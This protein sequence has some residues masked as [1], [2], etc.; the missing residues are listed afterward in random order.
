MNVVK[1]FCT[2]I[3]SVLEIT[4]RPMLYR[5]PYRTTAEAFKSDWQKIAGD[6]DSVMGKIKSE[7]DYGRD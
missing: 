5:Y 3:L 7:A 1:S 4:G 6:I 2:G